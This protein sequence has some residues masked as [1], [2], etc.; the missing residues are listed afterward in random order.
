MKRLP[1]GCVDGAS[2]YGQHCEHHQSEIRV[3]DRIRLVEYERLMRRAY[4]Q[5]DKKGKPDEEA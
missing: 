5:I 4:E 1:C 3:R 2:R